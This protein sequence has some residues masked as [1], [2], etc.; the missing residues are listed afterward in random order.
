MAFAATAAQREMWHLDQVSGAGAALSIPVAWR[1]RGPLDEQALQAALR[2][3]LGASEGLRTSFGEQDGEVLAH[4]MPVPESC[5]A[6]EDLA[7]SAGADQRLASFAAEPFDLTTGPLLRGLLLRLPDGDRLLALLFHHIAVDAWSLEQIGLDL[8]QAYRSALDQGQPDVLAPRVS[9]EETVQR[10][11]SWRQD[12]AWLKELDYWAAQLRGLT[13]HADLPGDGADARPGFAAQVIGRPLAAETARRLT[14]LARNLGLTQFQLLFAIYA[15]TLARWANQDDLV[16][17]VPVSNRGS[18]GA[19]DQSLLAV[20]L[21]PIRVR[22]TGDPAFSDVAS[23]IRRLLIEAM[24]HGSPTLSEIQRRCQSESGHQIDGLSDLVLTYQTH[25]GEGLELAGVHCQQVPVVTETSLYRLACHVDQ[26]DDELRIELRSRVLGAA[27]LASLWERLAAVADAVTASPALALSAWPVLRPGEPWRIDGG[28]VPASASA[29]AETIPQLFLDAS[30]DFAEALAV[31]TATERLTYWQFRRRVLGLAA[32]I[33]AAPAARGEP[34]AVCVGRGS[35]TLAAMHAVFLA[36]R[37]YL[38]LDRT[39]PAG[40]MR[41]ILEDADVSC[42]ICD[43]STAS[44]PALGGLTT[45]MAGPDAG[46][47]GS[48]PPV[49]PAAADPAYLIYTSG[50]S[51]T[52]KGVL[53]EHGALGW[54]VTSM[55]ELLNGAAVERILAS[56]A[57]VFDISLVELL[58]PVA[59]GAT[60]VVADDEAA[61]DP[62]LLA[63]F[64]AARR[65]DFAQA[66]PTFWSALLEHLSVRIPVAVAA[67]EPLPGSLRDRMLAIAD[68]ALNGYGP[69]ET[70]IYATV[71]RLEADV[72]VAIGAPLPG[73]SAWV[74]DRW[75][76]PCVPGATGQLLLG[77]AGVARGYLERDGALTGQRFLDGLATVTQE[78]VYRSGDLASHS[79]EGLLF[80]QG[81]QDDQVKIRGIRVEL[82]EIEAVLQAVDGVAAAAAVVFGRGEHNRAL[83]AFVQPQRGT[84]DELPAELPADL[85][86]RIRAALADQLPNAVR[87]QVILPVSAMPLMSSGKVDRV[88]LARRAQATPSPPAETSVPGDELLATVTSTF[89]EVLG[90]ASV[91]PGADFFGLG[92][93]SMGAARVVAKMRR[94]FS[95]PLSLQTFLDGPTAS[96]MASTIR[97]GLAGS[98]RGS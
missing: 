94:R 59:L 25:R 13:G 89:A 82:G 23:E 47:G 38:P 90:L 97:S 5:L 24:K 62:M 43:E 46:V 17:A 34:V 1:L 12:P 86:E 52:P 88:E 65:I 67:G 29:A 40:R 70:T 30:V 20:E 75:D 2:Q 18:S 39:W 22:L 77:G 48:L 73:A 3:V 56:T 92:G 72:P 81:R 74:L 84:P 26:Y 98:V 95:V 58:L 83:A 8:A 54:L 96:D 35:A 53:V 41:L 63:E 93:D 66:T 32:R 19:Q 69:T 68:L 55:R 76:R 10:I 27:D 60:C 37:V 91:G 6:V 71:W 21:L 33:E 16:V 57:S 61:R 80:V 64:I 49:R 31:E 11:N 51:G 87:P 9:L 15:G 28:P 50:S 4:I 85:R 44:L 42:V 7:D 36:G 14:P 45:I 79:A 78:R